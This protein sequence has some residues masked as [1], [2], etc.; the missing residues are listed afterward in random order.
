MRILASVFSNLLT[1]Q[2]VEKVCQTLHDA[3]YQVELIG[4]NWGGL[5]EVRRP[6]PVSRL[7]LKSKTLKLA[8]SEFNY[9][10]YREILKKADNQTILLANDLDALAANFLAARKHGIPLVYDSHEIYTEMPSVQ[11]RFTQKVWR[12]AEKKMIHKIEYMMTASN[13]YA[14]WFVKKYGIERPVVVQNFPKRAEFSQSGSKKNKIILYQGAINPSRGLDKI[15]PAMKL[16]PDAELW[17]AGSGPKLNEYQALTKNLGLDHKITF[18]GALKPQDLQEIT[19][20]ADVGLSIEENN[21]ESYFYSL[22]NKIS[23]YIRCGVP[24]VVSDFPEMKKIV[25]QYGVGE[26]IRDHSEQ[27]LAEKITKVLNNDREFYQDNLKKAATDL[28]WENE[29]PKLLQLF[30]KLETEN[31]QKR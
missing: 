1:D 28:C 22:P 8:Y 19:L 3:G 6:Y 12:L 21:G 15:I 20:K 4:N 10:L 25:N 5:P 18:F 9:R 30:H 26:I 29:V 2:R 31:F 16:L 24:I 17:I 27:E 13:S 7:Y 14:D 11:N 23:D